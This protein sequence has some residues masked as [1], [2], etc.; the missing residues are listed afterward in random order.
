MG[1]NRQ[2]AYRL[3]V[4][5][6]QQLAQVNAQLQQMLQGRGVMRGDISFE[7]L[8]L[9]NFD[10]TREEA[11]RL[12]TWAQRLTARLAP[13]YIKVFGISA[14]PPG[15]LFLRT[16]PS[17]GQQAY[18]SIVAQLN[19]YLMQYELPQVLMQQSFRIPA[20]NDC[21][22]FSCFEYLD[23]FRQ[24]TIDKKLSVQYIQLQR[25]NSQGVWEPLQ[26]IFL[27]QPAPSQTTDEQPLAVSA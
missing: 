17:A 25:L 24:L 27:Q 13:F 8:V 5:V 4:P 26:N 6:G 22:G 1:N 20:N 10:A 3:V 12:A 11:Q 21:V 7:W 23:L 18:L 15:R 14:Q 16:L 9:G 19:D 2:S